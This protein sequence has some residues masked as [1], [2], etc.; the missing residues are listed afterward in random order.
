M[1]GLATLPAIKR[2]ETAAVETK[3]VSTIST[4][5]VL[6]KKYMYTVV[7]CF[8]ISQDIF[9]KNYHNGLTLEETVEQLHCANC[10]R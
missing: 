3:S 6:R 7:F 10:N 9:W 8:R 1:V 2:L 5:N 4:I